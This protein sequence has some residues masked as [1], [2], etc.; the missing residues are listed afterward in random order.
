V[1]ILDKEPGS[2]CHSIVHIMKSLGEQVR[3]KHWI[4]LLPSPQLAQDVPAPAQAARH[5]HNVQPVVILYK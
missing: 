2:T 4:Q 5:R 3:I 1:K